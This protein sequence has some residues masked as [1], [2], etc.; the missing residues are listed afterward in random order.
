V[1]PG[2]IGG[3]APY[4]GRLSTPAAPLG[5]A[6][7]SNRLWIFQTKARR[8]GAFTGEEGRDPGSLLR[9]YPWRA[10]APSARSQC[11]ARWAVHTE[12]AQAESR[13]A[14]FW[15]YHRYCS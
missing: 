2:A 3:A 12:I 15:I 5:K 8:S 4:K 13:V 11:A 10:S 7:R 14:I 9:A 6:T 1:P